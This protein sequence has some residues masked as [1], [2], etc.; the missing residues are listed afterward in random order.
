MVSNGELEKR[1]GK[2]LVV[3]IGGTTILWPE[4]EGSGAKNKIKYFPEFQ[5]FPSHDRSLY[6][7]KWH[8]GIT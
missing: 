8:Y 6:C 1:A 5:S 2:I 3:T 4:G 7:D